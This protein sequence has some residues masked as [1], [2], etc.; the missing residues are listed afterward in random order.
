M[1]VLFFNPTSQQKRY[2]PFDALRGSTFFRRPNYDAMR[3]SAL[4]RDHDFV[5]YDERIEAK[6]DITPDIV[7]INVPL[8]LHSYVE[9]IARKQWSKRTSIIWYGFYPTLFP[10][11]SMKH[12]DS[13]VIGDI[14][15]IWRSICA[16]YT[17]GKLAAQYTSN[18]KDIFGTDRR[19]EERYGFTPV[20]SQL[21]TS[22][23]CS[24]TSA[25]KDF[26]HE[27]ILYKKVVHRDI[28]SAINEIASIKRKMVF[29]R[30]DDF[31]DDTDYAL[32]LLDRCWR[33][34][35]MWVFQTGSRLFSGTRIIPVLQD[36]GVRIIDLKEDWLSDHV[37]EHLDDKH[38]W[39]QKRREIS[40][41]H[42][43]RIACGCLLRLGKEGESFT[44]YK[45]LLRR[46][47]KSKI[48]FIKVSVR[49]PIPRTRT[50]EQYRKKGTIEVDT[51]FY[52]QWMP[53]V[54]YPAFSNQELYSWME[55]FRDRFYSWDSILLRNILVSTR[56]GFYNSIF[57]YLIPNLSYRNN[58][59]EKVGYPP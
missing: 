49:M 44:F 42:R 33:Y 51:T 14:V 1:K 9:R 20:L 8:Y 56:L 36:M 32:T 17:Q 28:A 47:V 52:D 57:F 46:L 10:K 26:C 6:P 25:N 5:Y 50:Y 27:N 31:L 40:M 12:A 34:K 37:Y 39:R 18:R 13:V 24:C 58:F 4:C 11:E 45:K 53:V 22:F 35:K 41:L 15:N 7:V 30:D 48:D 19:I 54:H 3:L 38:F 16:D 55:W 21:R 2:V 23:G 43:K 59:L 29:I